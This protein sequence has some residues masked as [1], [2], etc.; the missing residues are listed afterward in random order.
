M[1]YLPPSLLSLGVVA[2]SAGNHAQGV[3]LSARVLG[4]RAV[5]VMPLATPAI[6]V[7]SVMHHGGDNVEVVLHGQNYD[8]AAAEAR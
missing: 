2:C 5:I 7:S 3:A 8:E 1:S 6:K 4:A